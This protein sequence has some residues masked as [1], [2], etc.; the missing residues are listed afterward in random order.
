MRKSARQVCGRTSRES[1]SCSVVGDVLRYSSLQLKLSLSSRSEWLDARALP[2]L[3]MGLCPYIANSLDKD[4]DLD[5]QIVRFVP[6]LVWYVSGSAVGEG[7]LHDHRLQA[8]CGI[9]WVS[10]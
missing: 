6:P 1:S 5:F 8:E 4:E 3:V 9:C 7:G 10:P 2:P